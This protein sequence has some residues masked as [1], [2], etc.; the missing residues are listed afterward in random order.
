MRKSGRKERREEE[1]W[2]GKDGK[3]MRRRLGGLDWEIECLSRVGA[4]SGISA[5]AISAR[6]VVCGG[7]STF[8]TDF[9]EIFRE[10]DPV[11]LCKF[12]GLKSCPFRVF[13]WV[14]W[15]VLLLLNFKN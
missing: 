5:V 11:L 8:W 1:G 13:F 3:W 14:F 9:H 7:F 10:F 2:S 6:M 12:W 4:R 15:G